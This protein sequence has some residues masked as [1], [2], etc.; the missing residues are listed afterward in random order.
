M[1]VLDAAPGGDPLFSAPV[2]EAVMGRYGPGIRPGV[3]TIDRRV[4]PP[5]FVLGK[6]EVCYE[7]LSRKRRKWDP[8]MKP[9]LTGGDRAAIRKAAAAGRKLKR[10]KKQ[11]KKASRALEK[12]C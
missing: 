3:E 5:G 8:G 1:N 2:G 10:S 9:L 7:R 11:L 12:A 4:C 6:D